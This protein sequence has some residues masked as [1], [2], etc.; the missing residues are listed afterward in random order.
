MVSSNNTSSL[1][2]IVQQIEDLMVE[3]DLRG[4][5]SIQQALPA[6]YY[7]RAA[8]LLFDCK[9]TVLIGTGFPFD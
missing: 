1:T 3:R 7:Q 4:M 6:G 2:N 5:K 8:K 9:G